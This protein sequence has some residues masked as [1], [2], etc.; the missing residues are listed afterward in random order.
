L[1]VKYNSS[2]GGNSATKSYNISQVISDRQKVTDDNFKNSGNTTKSSSYLTNSDGSPDTEI[3]DNVP[4]IRKAAASGVLTTSGY[5]FDNDAGKIN[6]LSQFQ[7]TRTG[8][9][10][11]I[12]YAETGICYIFITKPDLN[13]TK[14]LK[15]EVYTV[16]ERQNNISMADDS[17]LYNTL[18][19]GFI[20][21]VARNYPDVIDSITCNNSGKQS[22]IPLLFNHFKSFSLEDHSVSEGNYSETWRGY[23]QKLPT[24]AAPSFGGGNF[25][26]IYDETNPPL[27][28]FLHKIWFEYMEGVKFNQMMPSMSTIN[29]REIDYTASLYY[30]L[31]APDG[32]TI[33]FWGKY[34]GIF[35][36][37]VPYSSFS[38][39][40]ISSR[41][42]I[43][44]TINYVYNH[45]E[46]LDPAILVDFNDTI[47]NSQDIF[48]AQANYKGDITSIHDMEE[49]QGK[50]INMTNGSSYDPGSNHNSQG[51][52]AMY[53]EKS[54]YIYQNKGSNLERRAFTNVG[55]FKKDKNYKLLF[56]N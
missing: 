54:A 52:R 39:G 27:I 37:N 34:T 25:S 12:D 22:F 43:Q 20:E 17:A 15:S 30:F 29:R 42:L 23:S 32:E 36:Q 8:V 3:F 4:H 19:N 46:F 35:P 38:G 53:D 24:T 56:Y 40:D 48:T 13:L 16:S 1:A 49:F 44:V 9:E 47:M 14:K 11:G 6:L 55:V 51:L 26:I 2:T 45:K 21:Y 41:N 33:V 7:K 10:T 5:G 18:Q 50:L 28:T 31:L